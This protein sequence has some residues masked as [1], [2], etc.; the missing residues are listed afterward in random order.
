M[1]E[2]KCPRCEVYW[3]SDEAGGGSVRLCSKCVDQLRSK[4]GVPVSLDVPFFVAAALFLVV[5]V[6]LIVCTAL[7][8][9]VFGYAVLIFGLVLVIVGLRVFR[10]F[11]PGHV[12]DADWTGARWSVLAILAGMACVLGAASFAFLHK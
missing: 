6:V 7:W 11:T 1:I 8:P 9:G 10:F 5:D 4:R 2:I 3:Y 12:G